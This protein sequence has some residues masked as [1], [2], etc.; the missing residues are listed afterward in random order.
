MKRPRNVQLKSVGVKLFVILFG[1][2]VLLSSVLGLT[3]YYAAK[4]IITDEVAAASSQSI[5][6]AA[7][8]LDFLFAEY[9]ALSRQFAVDSTLKADMELVNDPA[10]GTVAKVAAED[11]IRRKLDSV[12]GSDE[13]LV[14]I[15]LVS[16]SLVDAQS[17]KSAGVSA[18]RGGD[19]IQSRIKK[20]DEGKGQPV[21]FP[22]L[23]KGFFEMYSE[24]SMTMGRLLRNIQNPAAEYYM[25]IEIK[26]SALTD[27]LSN[28]HIGQTGEIRILD[29]QGSIV[30]GADNALLGQA[31]YIQAAAE[32]QDGQKQS[33][34]AKDEQGK[35]QLAVYQPLDTG[36]WTLLGY[37]PV[38]DFTKSAE[39]LLYITLAVVLAAALIA[40]LIGYIL[41]RLIGRPLG[42]LARLMEEGE[43]GNLQVRTNFKGQ[44]EIGRLGHSFNKMM[45]QISLLAGQ[46][47]R[48]AAEV[49]ATSEQ[50]VRASGATSNHAKEVAEATGEIAQGAA[51]LAA[52]A[53]ASNRNVEMMG[54]KM[55]EV[56]GINSIMDR[57]AERVLTVSDQGATLMQTLVKQSESTVQMMNLIQENS[58]MLQESTHLIRSIL[59]PM[60]AV[61]KQTNILALNAS[62]EAVRAGAAG[63]GFIVIADEIRG[64]A[65][66]SNQSIQS[67]SAITEEISRHIENT[68]KVVSEAGPL[69][70]EQIT[71][72]RESSVIFESVRTE[73]EAFLELIS[74]S[75]SSVA[76]LERFQRQ[77]GESMASVTSVVQQTSASTQEVA[78]MSSQ[79]FIVSEELVAL[80]AKLEELA[81][82]LKQSLVSFEG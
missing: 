46:S 19:E 23:D 74:E 82:N 72:V 35:S 16:R 1:T 63:K 12:K 26:G 68:V 25:L 41:V 22:V 69:F 6:Q 49:L 21:W 29:P 50:L 17:Y 9:E 56:A 36:G 10:A 67:V 18:V 75:S 64:L 45:E 30:Y 40:L 81:E 47:S 73:M 54:T 66:Q 58:A 57:T 52:E 14:A 4:G 8:K 61:N 5:V 62:I 43:Q 71:S 11:R 37:A 65:N 33:F 44:D 59:S 20:I 78:S 2:I 39:R 77:F 76:E 42:K 28:L 48:S 15:R 27:V 38:S 3:S 70:R 34:T 53:E 55:Q 79:Q 24:S 7:D 80:S 32:P 13:R 51:S 60:I 31:S